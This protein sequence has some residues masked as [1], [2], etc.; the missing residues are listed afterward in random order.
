MPPVRFT[1]K[2]NGANRALVAAGDEA[3]NFWVLDATNQPG[4]S[5]VFSL[6]IERRLASHIAAAAAATREARALHYRT[7]V[8]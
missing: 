5:E 4:P 3:G 1:G 6:S 7:G 8:R 2:V